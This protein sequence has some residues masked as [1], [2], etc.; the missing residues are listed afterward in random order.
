MACAAQLLLRCFAEMGVRDNFLSCLASMHWPTPIGGEKWP[1]AGLV[2][3][4]HV[5]SRAAHLALCC[6]VFSLTGWRHGYSEGPSVCG[7]PPQGAVAV[8]AVC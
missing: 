2:W 5:S 4:A 8:P 7:A 3:T 1:G 6:L